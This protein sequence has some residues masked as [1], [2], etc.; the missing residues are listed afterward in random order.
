MKKWTLRVALLSALVVLSAGCDWTMYRYGPAHSGFNNTES[1]VNV[2]N[3]A[4]LVPRFVAQGASLFFDSSPA[5]A[6]GVLF[7][8]SDNGLYAF[9]AKGVTNCSGT[10]KMCAPLWKSQDTQ[11][12]ASPAIADGIVYSS[13]ESGK[14]E[15]FDAKG[16]TNC[17]GTPKICSPLWTVSAGGG[18]SSPA[19]ANGIVYF[20]GG[21]DLNAYDANG[22]VNCSGTPKVCTPLWS[23]GAGVTGS[24][25]V[26]NGIVYTDT[27]NGLA[28]F[29]AANGAPLWQAGLNCVYC[30]S[31]PAVANGVVYVG[32]GITSRLYAY[33]ATS[34]Q[35]KWSFHA[36]DFVRSSPS[37]ANGVVYIG[38]FDW[39]VYG[40]DAVTGATLW[41]F[42]TGS[43]VFSA[44][45]IANGSVYAGSRCARSDCRN[46]SRPADRNR[47]N[48]QRPLPDTVAARSVGHCVV[49]TGRLLLARRTY[50]SRTHVGMRLRFADGTTSRVYRE[51]VVAHDRVDGPCVLVVKFRLRFVRGEL[52]HALFR[53]ESLLN[54]P[55]FVG[56]SGLVSKLWCAH[57]GNDVYRGFYEWDGADRAEHYAWSLWRV[58]AL[59]SEPSS[60][61]YVVVPSLTRDD[62]LARP[63][64]LGDA[65]AWARLTGV[66]RG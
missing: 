10:P 13:S 53:A 21:D 9:D 51:T 36:R 49:E 35:L 54:T 24:P 65:P 52:F 63:T 33:D 20:G 5:V 22:V 61:G 57:D 46:S 62:A 14:L 38:T 60:I 50:P 8:G 25:T 66:D 45:A 30:D 64:L 27:L 6:N 11:T 43:T 34:G 17:S 28:A 48:E 12:A 41:T 39:N 47:M 3:V 55:L 15:A 59:V 16:V 37:V 1:T 44:P 29:N 32:G 40:L 19:V 4:N 23:A 26:A 18:D 56:F 2:G 42:N 58:L 31:S 7:A